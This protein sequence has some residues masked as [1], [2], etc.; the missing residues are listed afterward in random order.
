MNLMRLDGAI[1]YELGYYGGGTAYF[2]LFA[3]YF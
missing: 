3:W 1:N 2:D